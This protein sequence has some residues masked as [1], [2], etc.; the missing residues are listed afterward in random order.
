MYVLANMAGFHNFDRMECKFR[1]SNIWRSKD[2]GAL[3]TQGGVIY[4]QTAEPPAELLQPCS[5]GVLLGSADRLVAANSSQPS[6]LRPH[7]P[8]RKYIPPKGQRTSAGHS[9]SNALLRLHAF[10]PFLESSCSRKT[11]ELILT[12]LDTLSIHCSTWWYRER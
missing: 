12:H 5:S 4:L 9:L 2:V 10:S 6:Y 11:R 3:S 1:K 8:H 7:D